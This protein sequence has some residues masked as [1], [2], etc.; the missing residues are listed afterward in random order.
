MP[1]VELLTALLLLP[2]RAGSSRSGMA[3]LTVRRGAPDG[4]MVPLAPL[5]AQGTRRVLLRRATYHE[6]TGAVFNPLAMSSRGRYM[7]VDGLAS[8]CTSGGWPSILPL[9]IANIGVRSFARTQ[10][11]AGMRA[12]SRIAQPNKRQQ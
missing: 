12:A 4:R 11:E 10:Q 9:L 7:L 5:L 2:T 3:L 1:G 6:F 8:S